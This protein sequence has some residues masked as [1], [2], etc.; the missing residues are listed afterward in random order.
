MWVN[1]AWIYS[2]TVHIPR[3]IHRDSRTCTCTC[4]RTSIHTH[5]DTYIHSHTVT[6]HTQPHICRQVRGR[7]TP[8]TLTALHSLT[9]RPTRRH[10]HHTHAHT[11]AEETSLR[12]SPTPRLPPTASRLLPPRSKLP[13][14]PGKGWAGGRW[15]AS[16]GPGR[17]SASAERV[18]PNPSPGSVTPASRPRVRPGAAAEA[19]PL[20]PLISGARAQAAGAPGVGGAGA[21]AGPSLGG[22]A[23]GAASAARS[24]PLP[25]A[26]LARSGSGRGYMVPAAGTGGAAAA[27]A[28][29]GSRTRHCRAPG[30]G[31]APVAEPRA[32]AERPRA[33]EPEAAKPR[34]LD[35]PGT[36]T[37]RRGDPARALRP[38]PRPRAGR[39]S[40][41]PATGR[42]P[43]LPAPAAAPRGPRSQ[44]AS[45]RRGPGGAPA[46]L[47]DS[48]GEAQLRDA[49]VVPRVGVHRRPRSQHIRCHDR[50]QQT[51]APGPKP[52]ARAAGETHGSLTE[53]VTP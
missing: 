25:A 41:E 12:I 22:A 28:S 46:S 43:A 13:F 49:N 37:G 50:A 36:R 52:R 10:P 51:W 7:L 21:A 20:P 31:A 8:C 35:F 19:Q 16:R 15:P 45:G 4:T 32:S 18:V 11:P 29:A 5:S 23:E 39:P 44:P 53:A 48:A 9:H 3:P 2:H 33:R 6:A 1:S 47:S 24:P 30:G 34:R 27:G 38:R 26:Y 40:Q 14:Q 17:D 42:G